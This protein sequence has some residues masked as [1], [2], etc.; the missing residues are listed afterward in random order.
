MREAS[1]NR[2]AL[3]PTSLKGVFAV[4]FAALLVMVPLTGC[5][6][7]QGPAEEA[8]EAVDEFM[9]ETQDAAEE[10][11]EDIEDAIDDSEGE[12]EEALS[13]N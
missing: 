8:G 1:P 5:V 4:L 10:V 3:C 13:R 12:L 2:T 7:D 11:M 9:D 6:E